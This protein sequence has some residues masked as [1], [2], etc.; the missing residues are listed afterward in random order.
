MK[1]TYSLPDKYFR[2]LRSLFSRRVHKG[3]LSDISF[4]K[5]LCAVLSGVM[6]SASFPP[7]NLDWLAWIALVPL[8]VIIK[9]ERPLSAF[10]LG[11]IA[12]LSHYATLVYWVIVAANVYGGIGL[13][14]SFGILLLFCFYLSLYPAFFSLMVNLMRNHL[15]MTITIPCIWV[16]LEYVRAVLITGFPWCLLGYS[17]FNMLAL[18]QISDI[19]GVYG[20]SFLIVAVNVSIYMLLFRKGQTSDKRTRIFEISTVAVLLLLA[21]LY[22]VYRISDTNKEDRDKQGNSLITSVI[23]G[24]IDQSLKWEPTLT[25][26]TVNK[27]IALT[28]STMDS[29]PGLIVWPEAATPFFFQED[30]EF[31]E[32]IRRAVYESGAYLIF[33]SPAYQREASLI[34]Y[35]NRVYLLDPKGASAGYYDKIH[36][37]PFGEYVPLRRFIP[38]INRMVMSTEDFSPGDRQRLLKMSDI[39][40]GALV[41]YE[42]VVPELAR[43]E[44]ENGANILI[45]LSNDAWFG[46]TSAP[47]QFLAMCVFRAVENR[48]PLIRAANTGFS[49]FID[50]SG[51]ITAR[52]GLFMDDVLT[53]EIRKDFNRITFYAKFGDMFAYLI[54]IICLIKFSHELWYHPIKKKRQLQKN[55]KAS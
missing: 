24:N 13:F 33:G 17:Q 20:V 15:F 54:I 29:K 48:R 43:G 26:S 14:T 21:Y 3:P 42:A 2:Y 41:C 10:K 11:M 35:Y 12:G 25:S 40:A 55:Q 5:A 50:P 4:Q 18:I 51:S 7:G 30:A 37:V 49:A 1:T 19:T 9:N 34:K 36:L 27:Y 32:E 16:S 23:Q 38:F 46:M 53:G 45:N 31:S 8:L 39:T 6:L 22:G 44:I 28:K 47:Y 52:S